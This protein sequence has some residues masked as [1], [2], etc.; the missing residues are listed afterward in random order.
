MGFSFRKSMKI[1]GAKINFGKKGASISTGIKGF[2]VST[3]TSGTRLTAGVGGVRYTTKI[4][5]STRRKK[6][7][8][9]NSN[10]T[11][12]EFCVFSIIIFIISCLVKLVGINLFGV[13]TWIIIVSFIMAAGSFLILCFNKKKEIENSDIDSN[14]E[15]NS[16]GFTLEDEL[17]REIRLKGEIGIL[18]TELL[19]LEFSDMPSKSTLYQAI[20][21]L[22][23]DFLIRKEKEG[24]TYRI[25]IR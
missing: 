17:L 10:M 22:E 8:N 2:R 25:F 19:N 9:A 24:R 16:H 15:I 14:S 3:G 23:S 12:S 13:V 21:N 7:A 20:K 18:Q 6:E 5:S 1:G 11:V 4:G